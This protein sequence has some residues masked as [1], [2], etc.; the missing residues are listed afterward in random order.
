[1]LSAGHGFDKQQVGTGLG[2][3]LGT[4]HRCVKAVDGGGIGAGHDDGVAIA[5]CIARGL[6][7]AD[8]FAGFNHFFAIEVA[9][10]LGADLVFQLDAVGP[11]A[12]QGAHGV[13]G[14]QRVAKAGV[15]IDDQRHLYRVADA[16]GVV[17]DVGQAHKALV[18]Q[19]KPHI[20]HASAGH[21]NGFKAHVGHQ[22]GGHGVER[23]GHDHAA[24]L[25]DQGAQLLLGG[26]HNN[27]LLCK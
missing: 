15:G 26:A 18:G 13:V 2:V 23:A 25:G 12:L 3:L 22:A 14:V 27:P 17:G 16:G 8:H 7:L 9:A 10:A 5:A 20:G 6:D 21:I 19:A 1:M 11:G 24:A 4:F